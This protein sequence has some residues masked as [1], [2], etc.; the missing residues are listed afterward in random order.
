[1]KFLRL[2]KEEIEYKAQLDAS[3]KKH[4][5]EFVKFIQKELGIKEE[6]KITLQND[7]SGIKTTAVYNYGGGESSKIKVYVGNRQLVDILR[8]IA[9]EMT[10]HMQFEQGKLENKPADVGGSIEDEANA[11]AGELIKKYAQQGNE[12]IYPKD[13]GSTTTN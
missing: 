2:L 6:I 12:D 1:M 3:K 13:D 9:H 10:H 5:E 7:K 11:R 4:V 8:S